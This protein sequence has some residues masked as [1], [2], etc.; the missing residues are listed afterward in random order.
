MTPADGPPDRVWSDFFRSNQ[1]HPA[2]VCDVVLRLHKAR[3]TEEVIACIEAALIHGQSQPWMYTVLALEMEK[4]GRPWEDVERVLLSNIDFSAINVDNLL[5]SAAF[6]TR[7]GAKD[8]ALDLYEQASRVDP[9]RLEPYVLGLKLARERREPR[10]LEWAA[11]GILT[12]AWNKDHEALHR[13][14][15]ATLV[16]LSERLRTEGFEEQ[17][18][19]LDQSLE[20][21]LQRD[22][23][24]ELSWS[25]KADLDLLVEE[26]SGTICSAENPSTAGG[27]VFVHDG[28]GLEPRD[29]FDKYVCPRGLSGDY[30]AIVRYIRGDVVGKR[31]VLRIV[32]YQG[33]PHEVE[34]RFTVQLSQEDK[35]VRISLR[36]GRLDE[37]TALPPLVD[38]PAPVGARVGNPREFIVRRSSDPRRFGARGLAGREFRAGGQP[39]GFQP[40]ITVLSEG[41]A[42]NA[43]A[44]VSGDRRY[45]RLSLAPVFSAI[46]GV[47][48]FSFI[49][50]GD[51]NGAGGQNAGQ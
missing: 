9:T 49:N 50:S 26:P 14:A 20:Q 13:E 19:R 30:R 31:A 27:G 35:V 23:V 21:A 12:R 22:L 4:A 15:E 46:T 24:I 10:A 25:G 1:P 17:A 36:Q 37:T 33:T 40:V 43:L 32:R 7:F 51:P 8:R 16:E 18:A 5:Y 41:V 44:V 29:A 2:S 11:V 45:V 47:N 3:K 48:T 34:E 38:R 42:L 6:L 28:L 39:V